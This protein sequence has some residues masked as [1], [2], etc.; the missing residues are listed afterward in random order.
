MGG[1]PRVLVVDDEPALVRVLERLLSA[2]VEVASCRDGLEALDWVAAHGEPA[3]ILC[4]VRL[5]RLDGPRLWSALPPS[6]RARLVF[7]TGDPNGRIAQRLGAAGCPV[8]GKPFS[9][10]VVRALV[11]GRCG[12]G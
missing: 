2:R 10:A 5:P 1:R 3:L 12:V 9:A 11:W 6:C 7:M 4:D 8:L